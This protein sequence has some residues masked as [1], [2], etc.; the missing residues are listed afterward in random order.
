M[1][2]YEI[3]T[4]ATHSFGKFNEL[5]NNPYK[6]IKVLGMG[7]KW[8]GY[9]MKSQLVY[10]Y[11]KNMDDNKIIIFLDGFDSEINDNPDKSIQI[12]KSNN[13]KLLFSKMM[14]ENNYIYD[15]L[16]NEIYPY[17]FNK[18]ISNCGMYI[19]YVKYLKIFYENSLKSKCKDDQRVTNLLCKDLN[20]INVDSENKIFE[21]KNIEDKDIKSN[22]IFISYPGTFSFFRISR[23]F[24]EYG[25]FFLK[26]ILILY[27]LLFLFLFYI[28]YYKSLLIVS[29]LLIF[30]L[31]NI[32]YSCT[33]F[34]F[35]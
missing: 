22:A 11:I 4:V 29:I 20:F 13:Y 23:A 28:K 32:D 2:D 17:C 19:G 27:I 8:T 3:V 21:N 31:F 24:L 34:N 18:T 26:Y 35:L 33:D 15:N 7:Q 10:D 9:K 16:W 6:K 5:I 1:N 30:Y 12:F 25:Q 14:V